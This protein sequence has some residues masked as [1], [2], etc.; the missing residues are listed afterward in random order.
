MG[1]FV[2]KRKH[3]RVVI[4]W[5]VVVDIGGN[6]L[7]CNATKISVEG[8]GLICDEPLPIDEVVYL[9]LSPP[10]QDPI[11]LYGK[12]VWS[13]VYGIDEEDKVFGIGVFFVQV[14]RKES[15]RYDK[16]VQSLLTS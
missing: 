9:S 5:P 6:T 3:P 16:L 15:T 12:I 11:E 10:N 14:S 7:E 13:D 4:D 2:E 1:K 8:I